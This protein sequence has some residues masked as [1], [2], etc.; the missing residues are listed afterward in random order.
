MD[1]A[2]LLGVN[3]ETV[4]KRLVEW[5]VPRH[6]A[7]NLPRPQ[8]NKARKMEANGFWKGG[9][10]VDWNGY[11][12]VKMN[13][14]PD[15]NH[16]GYVREH[17]L[18]MQEKIGRPLLPGEVVHHRDEDPSNNS[19]DN[20]RLYAS[21]AEHLADTLK[22]KCPAWTEE[23]RRKMQQNGQRQGQRQ[24]AILAALRAYAQAHSETPDR[25]LASLSP[26][27]RHLCRMAVELGRPAPLAELEP[28][29]ETILAA[30]LALQSKRVRRWWGRKLACQS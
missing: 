15:A 7:K 17:R 28:E 6:P 11:V 14:H 1:I 29:R 22:S 16:I 3:P 24:A 30:W 10:I 12:L 19:P 20:L 27:Q 23:G 5:G 26:E 21:N 18:V 2:K 25:F 9:K 13:D 4:R 8:P